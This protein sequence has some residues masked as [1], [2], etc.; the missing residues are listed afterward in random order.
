MRTFIDGVA[1]AFLILDERR[2]I[3][4][5]NRAFLDL[6]DVADEA[7]I[8]SFLPG[9]GLRCINALGGRDIC[10]TTESCKYCG[11]VHA[12]S[13]SAEGSS[14]VRECRM[15]VKGKDGEPAAM[16]L[17]VSASPIRIDGKPHKLVSIFDVGDEKRRQSLE[18]V[19]FHDV[20]GTAG[21]ID[22]L[23]E[24]LL[25]GRLLDAPVL[26]QTLRTL[27]TRLVSEI[28]AQRDLSAAETGELDVRRTSLRARALLESAVESSRSLPVAEGRTVRVDPVA[29]DVALESDP[30]LIGRILGHMIR[31]ALEASSPGEPVTA[32]C[33]RMPS[34]VARFWVR[35]PGAMP[36]DVQTQVFQ[37]SYSTKGTG[38]GLG[39]Y[40]MKLLAERYLGGTVRF[41]SSPERGTTFSLE[42]PVR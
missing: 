33:G 6:F 35:N 19:F 36:P 28:E 7:S 26:L 16:D 38:H 30:T 3:V 14:G 4:A 37:R 39:T 31:N 23:A 25:Q 24:G 40:S 10:G 17:R 5:C 27:T 9:E 2:R 13:G 15:R 12:I 1:E 34:G 42:V 21:S 11:L 18:R 22:G 20:L 32:G 29:E 41:H 8:R